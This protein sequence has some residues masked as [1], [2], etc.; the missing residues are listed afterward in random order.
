MFFRKTLRLRTCPFT[1]GRARDHAV[2]RFLQQIIY[3]LQNLIIMPFHFTPVPVHPVQY[4]RQIYGDISLRII[5][6]PAPAI[7][8]RIREIPLFRTGIVYITRPFYEKACQIISIYRS[9]RIGRGICHPPMPLITL[10]TVCG[11]PHKITG[12]RL[13]HGVCYP[14]QDIMITFKCGTFR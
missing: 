3:I 7:W 11:N 12:I 1:I 8:R 5:R 2:I 13:P 14:V 4:Q 9:L 10:R 6:P